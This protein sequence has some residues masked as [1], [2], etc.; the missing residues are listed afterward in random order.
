M[1]DKSVQK[2]PKCPNVQKPPK[3]PETTESILSLL[4]RLALINDNHEKFLSGID[5]AKTTRQKFG[6]MIS[7]ERFKLIVLILQKLT[8]KLACEE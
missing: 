4:N 6:I 8:E 3:V 7:Q 1:S 2:H 5:N